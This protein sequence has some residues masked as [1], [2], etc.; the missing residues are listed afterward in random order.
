MA[1]SIATGMGEMA[2]SIEEM[3]EKIA[4]PKKIIR[5]KSGN[6]VG[7]ETVGA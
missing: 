3:G 4:A 5:D 6:I 2:H 1:E 7:A